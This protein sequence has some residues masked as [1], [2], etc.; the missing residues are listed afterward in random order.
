MVRFEWKYFDAQDGP[1]S[2][3]LEVDPH[4]PHFTVEDLGIERGD[5]RELQLRGFRLNIKLIEEVYG[6]LPGL[7]LQIIVQGLRHGDLK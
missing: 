6:P 3:V 1:S 5:E 2:G 7:I 4:W